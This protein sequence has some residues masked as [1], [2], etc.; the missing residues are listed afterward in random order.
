MNNG[1]AR[2]QLKFVQNQAFDFS[3]AKQDLREKLE[4]LRKI[5]FNKGIW[6]LI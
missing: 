2:T 4:T 3:S 6:S 5:L 1:M